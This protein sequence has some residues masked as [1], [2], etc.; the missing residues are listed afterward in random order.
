MIWKFCCSDK[1][2]IAKINSKSDV[3]QFEMSLDKTRR[4]YTFVRCLS[5]IQ[6]TTLLRIFIIWWFHLLITML[7]ITV[8][9]SV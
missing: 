9:L 5:K 6:Y 3:R 2:F 1:S 4:Y 7:N 8:I